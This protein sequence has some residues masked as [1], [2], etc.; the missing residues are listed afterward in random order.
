M[1]SCAPSEQ[2]RGWSYGDPIGS[3]GPSVE[4]QA[5]L[6][7]VSYEPI[8]DII[9]RLER[10]AA[11][12]PIGRVPGERVSYPG[13]P[14]QPGPEIEESFDVELYLSGRGAWE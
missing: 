2:R 12:R 5:A 10:I 13:R 14:G 6:M 4:G 1:T 7:A 11:S 9:A 3:A 8:A